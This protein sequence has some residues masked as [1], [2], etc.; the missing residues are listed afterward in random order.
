M[1]KEIVLLL[2]SSVFVLAVYGQ[3]PK[4]KFGKVSNEEL[5]MT[6][7]KIDTNAAAVVLYDYGSFNCDGFTFNKK[8]RIKILKESGLEYGDFVF[9][10]YW[11][12]DVK[13]FT[14]NLENGEV[15]KSKLQRSSI[16]LENVNDDYY[17]LKIAMP[18][19]KVG[20]VI[21]IQ[22]NVEGLPMDWYFQREIPVLYSELNMGGCDYVQFRK[23]FFGFEPLS[24]SSQ[25]QWV[26][27]NM[28]AF[29]VEPH[30]RNPMDYMTRFE[31]EIMRIN[32]PGVFINLSSDWDG[33]VKTLN[34][35]VRFGASFKR[36]N[37][38]LRSMAKDIEDSCTTQE[39]KLK[40]AIK[41]IQQIKWNG[42]ERLTLS[43]D[44]LNYQYKKGYGSSADMN[45]GLIVLLRKLDFEAYPVVLSTRS[46]GKLSKQYAS[47][48]KL[49]YVL[50]YV[51]LNDDW[52][53]VDATE[54]MLPYY[55]LPER[56]LNDYGRIADLDKPGWVDITPGGKFKTY[57]MYNLNVNDDF[58]ITG[59]ND[60]AYY[61]YAAYEKRKDY[62][63]SSDKDEYIQDYLTKRSNVKV[64]DYEFTD[65]DS[66]YKPVKENFKVEIEN[67]VM[68]ADSLVYIQL[69]PFEQIKEN[70]FN[71][72]KRLY[73]IDFIYPIERSGTITYTIPDNLKV[74]EVPENLALK[75]PDNSIDY[76]YSVSNF[77]N[78][79][80]VNYR[81]RINQYFISQLEYDKIKMLYGYILEK[82]AEPL[83]LKI[84]N[85]SN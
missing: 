34:E 67:S 4:I 35:H 72:E 65:F 44:D 46:S 58:T 53:L 40:A 27:E 74:I 42:D 84:K 15:V 20:S 14:F 75:M 8:M 51:K 25:S 39:A 55:L 70:P 80:I 56:C 43:F 24:Y 78:K 23:N 54:E 61:D 73:P 62:Y 37:F 30:M 38:F 76:T 66:I 77:G 60:N 3:K 47:L 9:K 7:C 31:I 11:K 33:V 57:A 18:N 1:K 41:D 71:E 12:S 50:A 63:T 48:N 52:I 68:A 22:L 82:E 6:T 29:K 81:L 13:G 85:G 5:E 32:Y 16:F 69:M 83:V 64:N 10:S 36:A 21:D 17:R 79:V 45:I 26:A 19:V 2:L 49:N 59:E 28:P